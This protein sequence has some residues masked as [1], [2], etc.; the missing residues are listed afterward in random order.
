[1]FGRLLETVFPQACVGCG[2]GAWPFCEVCRDQIVAFTPPWCRRCGVPT[3]RELGSCRDCPPEPIALARSAFLFEGPIRRGVHRLKFSGWRAVAEGLGQAMAMVWDRDVA[4]VTWVPL[5][6]R[7]RAER[8]FDQAELLARAV[9]PRLGVRARGLLARDADVGT[10]AR[11]GGQERRLAMR[12]LF[13]A[14]RPVAGE[15]LLVDDVLT[16]GATAA[17]CA[18]ALVRAGAARVHVLTAARAVSGL[19]GRAP[20]YSAKGSRPGLWLPGE[21]LP[22]SRCQPRAKR[23]T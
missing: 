8:G 4:V 15:V 7:R 10:Q 20:I 13:H 12:G 19:R 14:T 3:R 18:E 9:G 21:D 1:M 11:R 16:T 6:R 22:G 17:A 23:P 5:S 2:A